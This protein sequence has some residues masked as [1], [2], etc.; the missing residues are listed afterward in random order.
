MDDA[1]CVAVA[2]SGGRDSSALLHATLAAA[3]A[4]GLAVVALHVHHGLSARADAWLAHC[5]RHCRRLVRAGRLRA[6]ASRRLEDRPGKGQ[7]VEAW[8]REARYAAL[9]EMALAQG[10]AVVLLAQHRRDQAETVLLQALR[11][12][13]PAGL[14]AMPKSIE[15]AGITWLRPWLDTPWDEIDAYV[16]RHRLRY[17]ED[18]SNA[19]PR[20]ARNRLRADVWPAL[21]A[22]FPQAEAALADVARWAQEAQL[23]G[24]ELAAIDLA[25][26]GD[27]RG[28]ALETWMH[29]SAPRRSNALRAWLKAATDATVPSSLVQR[30]MHEL[31]DT[32]CAQWPFGDHVLHRY[33]GRLTCAP[34]SEVPTPNLIR[35]TALKLRRA[36]TFALPD[37]GGRLRVQRVD[38]GG[39]PASCLN[40]LRLAAR[41]GGEQFQTALGRPP[42]SLKKQFQAQGVPAWSRGG[43]LLYQGGRLLFV[44]GLGVDARARASEGVPQVGFEW[45]PDERA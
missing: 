31:S 24:A 38:R 28:L 7:S 4:Q 10:A 11:G 45:L 20:F 18:D 35:E 12:A 15:R 27:A 36:G 8:A 39:V 33:R 22:A 41:V 19:D 13:G 9:L 44:P 6:F 2:Y 16:R 29:L 32:S 21:Q 26:V 3:A 1:P 25:S 5:E 34:I 43:P 17:V 14:S 23:C 42:R 30:L 40:D 37:W